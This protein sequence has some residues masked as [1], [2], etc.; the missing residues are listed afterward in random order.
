MV[1][2]NNS[3]TSAVLRSCLSGISVIAIAAFCLPRV[4]PPARWAFVRSGVNSG[5]WKKQN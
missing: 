2:L 1:V 5:E 4:V 3:Q